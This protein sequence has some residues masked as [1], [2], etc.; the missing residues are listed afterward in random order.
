LNIASIDIGT[1]TVLLLITKVNNGKLIPLLNRYR[2]PRL[3][4]GLLPHRPISE[5]GIKA[6]FDILDEYRESIEKFNCETVLVNATNAF[7]IASNSHEIAKIIK[8]KYGYE[9]N[10]IS[11][12]KEAKLSFLGAI[13]SFQSVKNSLVID[14]GGGS[15]EII[16]GNQ[17]SISFVNSFKVGVVS[18]TE[19]FIK[20][21]PPLDS[22]IQKMEKEISS[23]FAILKTEIP[24]NPFTIAVAG[25]P[26]TLSCIIQNIKEYADNLVEQSEISKSDLLKYSGILKKMKPAEILKTFGKIV[27]GREDVLLAGVLILE[28][29]SGLL[30]IDK[31][32]VS[33]RGIR[34]GAVIDWLNKNHKI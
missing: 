7:R 34:Y 28:G 16:Y 24:V 1:N 4:K 17:K 13:S 31:Y 6:L 9:V 15:T 18:L 25:T 10:I 5:D 30:K 21:S 27:D 19:K 22:E 14:I 20:N 23:I 29:I 12:E 2:M 26:T 8:Q 3:G 32:Y 11:G 33:S